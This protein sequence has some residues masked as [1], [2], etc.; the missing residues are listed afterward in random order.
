MHP[1]YSIFLVLL[2]SYT[3]CVSGSILHSDVYVLSTI[4]VPVSFNA[5]HIHY[6]G[7]FIVQLVYIFLF[8]IWFIPERFIN[9]LTFLNMVVFGYLSPIGIQ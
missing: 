6:M 5:Y 9:P 2:Y 7:I 3:H 8:I 4:F 1:K